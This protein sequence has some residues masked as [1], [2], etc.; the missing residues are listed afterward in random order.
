MWEPDEDVNWGLEGTWLAHRTPKELQDTKSALGATEMGLIYVN[1][2]GPDRNH[3]PIAAIPV[4]RA[5]STSIASWPWV[6]RRWVGSLAFV[7]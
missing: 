1:P 7:V 3:D 5:N 6:V 4:I 2:E